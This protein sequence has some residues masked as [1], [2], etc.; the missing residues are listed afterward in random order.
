MSWSDEEWD[1]EEV[2]QPTTQLSTSNSVPLGPSTTTTTS[3]PLQPSSSQLHTNATQII[4]PSTTPTVPSASPRPPISTTPSKSTPTSS[5]KQISRSSRL[6]FLTKLDTLENLA[7][8]A[9][10]RELKISATIASMSGQFT[11]SGNVELSKLVAHAPNAELDKKKRPNV[12]IRLRNPQCSAQV[13]PSGFVSILGGKTRAQLYTASRQVAAIIRHS[14]A[15]SDAKLRDFKLNNI[16]ISCKTPLHVQKDKM[17]AEL[18]NLKYNAISEQEIFPC[19][20]VALTYPKDHSCKVFRTG[21]LIFMGLKSVVDVVASI[22]RFYPILQR[23]SLKARQ[24]S[25]SQLQMG[26]IEYENRIKGNTPQNNLDFDA[27]TGLTAE[28]DFT[29][30][31]TEI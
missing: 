2:L 3:Q 1:D 16:V 28:D 11:V 30:D 9:L 21:A 4:P 19:L 14:Q 29:L 22:Q 10:E 7:L 13:N 8:Q 20:R 25:N 12:H 26:Y 31:H 15:Y 5:K 27:D 6:E 23:L 18:I 17:E 24:E